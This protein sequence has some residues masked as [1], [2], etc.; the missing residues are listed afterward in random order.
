MLNFSSFWAQPLEPTNTDLTQDSGTK[1]GKERY[2]LISVQGFAVSGR[3]IMAAEDAIL[4]TPSTSIEIGDDR[5]K[6]F[7]KMILNRFLTITVI[8]PKNQGYD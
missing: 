2:W 5:A 4:G 3:P 7:Y 1:L 8:I 6:E